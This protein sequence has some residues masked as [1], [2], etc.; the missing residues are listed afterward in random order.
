MIMAGTGATRFEPGGNG[1]IGVLDVPGMT[2][3]HF[4][5]LAFDVSS[6]SSLDQINDAGK[7]G[8][9]RQ[10]RGRVLISTGTLGMGT[11]ELMTYS[12][13]SSISLADFSLGLIGGGSRRRWRITSCN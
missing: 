2:L 3:N 10:R 8:L 6:T 12:P 4:S 9:Q 11:Y 1:S 7:S 13:T 5:T